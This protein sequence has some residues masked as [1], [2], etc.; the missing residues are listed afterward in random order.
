LTQ[1]ASSASHIPAPK[2]IASRKQNGSSKR[3]MFK[4][5]PGK[6]NLITHRPMATTAE[7]LNIDDYNVDIDFADCIVH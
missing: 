2:A 6:S 7:M 3:I 4:N 5:R 1:S